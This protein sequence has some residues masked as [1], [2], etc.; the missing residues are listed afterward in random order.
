MKD[1]QSIIVASRLRTPD[2]TII[3]SH[4]RHDYV[5]HKDA[6]GREYML[7]GGLDYVRRSAHGDEELMTVTLDDPHK[8]VRESCT[9]GSR[10][11]DGDQPLTYKKLCDMDA[12]HI[13]AVLQNV[14]RIYPSIKLAMENELEYRQSSYRWRDILCGEAQELSE[15]NDE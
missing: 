11:I 9:W 6:N 12:S 5:T 4:H 1:N 15:N 10:G 2:G 14:P 8:V 7:D 13:N 3:Q